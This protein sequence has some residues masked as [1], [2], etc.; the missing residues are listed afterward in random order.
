MPT[1]AD[2]NEAIAKHFQPKQDGWMW[3]G[4]PARA[5][6]I[7]AAFRAAPHRE[8]C[9]CHGT[10]RVAVNLHEDQY[11]L[12]LVTAYGL[13]GL[14]SQGGGA[15][16]AAVIDDLGDLATGNGDLPWACRRLRD[17]IYYRIKETKR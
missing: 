13:A 7:D 12:R 9:T 11:T 5:N 16:E 10:G 2:K 3:M 4:C 6:A 17:L 8:D 15:V 1:D 14:A